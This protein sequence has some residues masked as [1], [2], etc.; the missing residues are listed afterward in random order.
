MK[1]DIPFE[2]GDHVTID[3]D[4]S[5]C[6]TVLGASISGKGDNVRLY[7][8]WAHNGAMCS[9]EVEDWRIKLWDE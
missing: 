2:V 1:I 4:R 9:A 3:G 8:S 7:L 5:I 6:A